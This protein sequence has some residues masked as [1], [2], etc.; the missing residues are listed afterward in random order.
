MPEFYIPVGSKVAVSTIDG[1]M[2]GTVLSYR[3]THL[4][5]LNPPT[6]INPD[7]PNILG[8]PQTVVEPDLMR[9]ITLYTVKLDNPEAWPG[10]VEPDGT[11]TTYKFIRP[12]ND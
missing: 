3:D 10:I 4:A 1:V 7:K 9:I 8:I 11:I 12:I 2:T 5:E 6:P